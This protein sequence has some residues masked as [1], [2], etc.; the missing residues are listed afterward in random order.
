MGGQ[1]RRCRVSC[2]D[3]IGHDLDEGGLQEAPFAR[4][5][6]RVQELSQPTAPLLLDPM[7]N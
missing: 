3:R 7:H 6:G 2:R 5:N 4:I 1:S